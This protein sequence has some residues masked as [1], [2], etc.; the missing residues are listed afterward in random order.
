MPKHVV[1]NGTI[2]LQF[3]YGKNSKKTIKEEFHKNNKIQKEF[4]EEMTNYISHKIKN[5]LNV[6]T[7]IFINKI[8]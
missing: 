2:V 3:L 6:N 8:I 1:E 4:I 7:K 5:S